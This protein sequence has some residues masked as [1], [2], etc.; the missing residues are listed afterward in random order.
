MNKII[1]TT[2][3]LLGST[4]VFAQKNSTN[5]KVQT[6]SN[7]DPHNPLVNG[8]PYDQYKIQVQAEEKKKIA[9]ENEAKAQLKISEEKN[10]KL[11]FPPVPTESEKTSSFPGKK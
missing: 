8:I 11:K 5:E 7:E 6:V 1:I 2:V 4:L 3:F 10:S 9:A